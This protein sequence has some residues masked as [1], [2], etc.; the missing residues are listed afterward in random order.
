MLNAAAGRTPA[1]VQ[2][3]RL[4]LVGQVSPVGLDPDGTLGVP[5]D[6]VTVGWWQR[7]ALPGDPGVALL[8]AH[9]DYAHVPGVFF[10]L[11]QVRVGDRVQ[12]QG[13]DGSRSRWRVVRTVT[14]PKQ[15]L[16]VAE[17][18]RADGPPTLVLV[19]CGGSFDA[20]KHSYRANVIVTAVPAT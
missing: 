13:V 3:A 4:G 1:R 6:A 20:A 19:T 18:T 11:A 16:P 15:R 14:T 2:L 17:L 9:V 7:G 8:A 10:R 5:H 12:V